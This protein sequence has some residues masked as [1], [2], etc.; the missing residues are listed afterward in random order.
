[1]SL[2]LGNWK[3]SS[4][5]IDALQK[6]EVVL[7]A[8]DNRCKETVFPPPGYRPTVLNTLL[9]N[10]LDL[11]APASDALL[12]N[13]K[14]AWVQ[15]AGHPGSFAPAG[16]HSIWKKRLTK[17]NME[18]VAYQSLM[19]DL[20]RDIIPK[21][22]REVEYNGDCFIEIEDLLQHFHD[23]N[24]MD[25]KMGS[26]TFLE[27]E[28]KNP[29][30]RKDLYEKMI[31]LDPTEPT[32]EEHEQKAITKLRYM[33]FR[34]K[35]SSTSTLGF[36]IEAM[37]LSGET[38]STDL[39]KLR[40]KPEVTRAI[41]KFLHFNQAVIAKLLRRFREMRQKFE[42]STFFKH[43][44]V[45]GS[46]ILVMYDH[47]HKASAWMI[48]FAKTLHIGTNLTLTHRA[49]WIVGNH[50]DGYL[51]ALD[52]LIEI[53]MEL[54]N[55]NSEDTLLAG[56]EVKVEDSKL[57]TEK[58]TANKEE[59]PSCTHAEPSDTQETETVTKTDTPQNTDQSKAEEATEH[60]TPS[61]TEDEKT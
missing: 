37:R 43:H 60:S 34:E 45:I 18:T 40:T 7:V 6:K 2:C 16:P 1:M 13:R 55:H 10:A 29:V 47:N 20:V 26:R 41:G 21:F 30:L 14:N 54:Q 42:C 51:F 39:K 9:A 49:P 28:V 11:T 61:N 32:P 57:D 38:T 59:I 33:Q 19:N 58:K 56:P 12:K 53:L 52:N 4:E 17:E 24:I 23:P 3:K 44:E 36:R 15:L 48:D 27:S 25:I 8:V 35:G 22:Y 5:Q 46:S 50:E 31:K